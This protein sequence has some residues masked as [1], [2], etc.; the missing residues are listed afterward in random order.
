MAGA[1]EVLSSP[2]PTANIFL[3][4]ILAFVRFSKR[5]NTPKFSETC[6]QKWEESPPFLWRNLNREEL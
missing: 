2:T 6:F 4:G 3:G 1:A 5:S